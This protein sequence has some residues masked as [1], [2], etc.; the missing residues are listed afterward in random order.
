MRFRQNFSLSREYLLQKLITRSSSCKMCI[1]D[2]RNGRSSL[3]RLVICCLRKA[4]L[5]YVRCLGKTN[6][7]NVHSLGTKLRFMYGSLRIYLSIS[8][9]WNIHS[10]CT[11]VWGLSNVWSSWHLI[12]DITQI[13]EVVPTSWTILLLLEPNLQTIKVKHVP[14]RKLFSNFNVATA[15]NTQRVLV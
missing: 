12:W 4:N 15:N 5:R 8:N 10:W 1:I 3:L 7:R 6:L 11:N 2:S 13:C 14:A 9:L